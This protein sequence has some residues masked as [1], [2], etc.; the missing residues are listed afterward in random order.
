M[1]STQQTFLIVNGLIVTLVV[2]SFFLMRKGPRP[3]VKLDLSTG[4]NEPLVKP[5]TKSATPQRRTA[6]AAAPQAPPSG[7]AGY[8]PRP[9]ASQIDQDADTSP[10]REPQGVSDDTGGEISLNVLFN[11]NGHT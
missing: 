2:L 11:W 3:P 4:T 1:S 10:G 7:W 9:R 8:K 5:K 6:P